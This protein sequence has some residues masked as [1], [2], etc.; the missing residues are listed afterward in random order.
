MEK[1]NEAKSKFII[2]A[3]QGLIISYGFERIFFYSFL[4]SLLVTIYQPNLFGKEVM[5]FKGST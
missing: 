4:L 2:D 3:K 5:S 1:I